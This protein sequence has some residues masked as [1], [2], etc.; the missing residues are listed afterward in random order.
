MI[1][2]SGSSATGSI[3]LTSLKAKR[4]ARPYVRVP[5]KCHYMSLNCGD[6]LVCID[7]YVL[8]ASLPL[9]VGSLTMITI[10]ALPSS[11]KFR[12]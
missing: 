4:L 11:G 1:L 8:V 3:C 7:P 9:T 2:R 12:R 10:S 6:L 5:G